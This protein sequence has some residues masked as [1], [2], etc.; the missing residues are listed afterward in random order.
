MFKKILVANRSEIACRI[1]RACKELGIATVAI[2]SDIDEN[3]LHTQLADESVHIGPSPANL[4]YLNQDAVINAALSSGCDAIHPGYGFLSEKHSFNRKVRD[5]GLS[6]IGPEPEPMELLGSKVQSRIIMTNAGVPVIP[7]MKSSSLNIDEF[8]EAADKIGYPVLIKA[9]DGGGGKGMRIVHKQEDLKASVEAA[10]RESMSAFG[11]ESVFLEKY[12][13][14]PRHVEFQVAADN[15][16]NAVYL[17]ERECSIQ[18]RHQKII[19][20]TPSTIM[21]PD[22]RKIMGETA[23]RVIKATNYNNVGTVEFLVDKNKNFYFLEVNAR[24]QVEHPITEMVTGIDLLKLQINLAAGEKMPFTQD[25]LSQ[26]GHAI[27]CRIYAEDYENNFF[28]SSGKILYLKEPIGPGVRYDSGIFQGATISVFYD[29]ILA[30]LITY[31]KDREEARHRML[32]ALKENIILG[33]KTSIPYMS[34]V[35][36]HPEFIAGNTFTNFIENHSNSIN[37]DK[38]KYF[39][40][41][42]SLAATQNSKIVKTT[43]EYKGIAGIPSPWE[44]IGNWEIN[45]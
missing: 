14:S 15:Y 32:N 6:F 45:A 17:F 39:E 9:S 40:Q 11:S 10:I 33:V 36:E 42:L 38:N 7:G 3:S 43:K 13:E 41:A 44:L 37:I 8:A 31:G 1:I 30:K 5:A 24:I 35:L 19:E 18:R 4:S 20:E 29:P 28:P 23:V 34:A 21:D 22:L 25:Q 27:E 16:G 12:I 2:Y 26:N